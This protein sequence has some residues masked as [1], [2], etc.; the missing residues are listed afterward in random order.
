M[1]DIRPYRPSD[2]DDV[3]EICLATGRSGGHGGGWLRWDT[4]LADIWALPYVDLCPDSAYVADVDGRARGYILCAPDTR[5]FVQQ[6]RAR[7]LPG[8]EHAYPLSG[9]DAD[10]D[11]A[12]I[13]RT[14][15]DIDRLLIPELDHYPAHL[16]IDLLPELQ[17][18]GSGRVLMRTLLAEL[19]SRGVSGVWL[20]YAADNTGAAAFYRR[21]GFEPLPS[22][23]HG[24]RVGIRT[25]ATV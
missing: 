20:E 8:F 4:L 13:V 3:A 19:R 25:D 22:G 21:L 11:T 12:R 16:H 7:W 1:A 9:V 17:G 6:L 5:A 10:S 18:Q 24:T 2:R 15:R 14:G 23:E